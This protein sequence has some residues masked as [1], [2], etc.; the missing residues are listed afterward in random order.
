[1]IQ[2]V[3]DKV[4]PDATMKTGSHP[5]DSYDGNNTQ[6]SQIIYILWISLVET[7]TDDAAP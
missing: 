6:I 4:S 5:V 1:M 2:I 7:C 3:P